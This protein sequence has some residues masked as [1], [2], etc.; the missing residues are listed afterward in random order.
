MEPA[1]ASAPTV[2]KPS[3]KP[4]GAR[5]PNPKE[6]SPGMASLFRGGPVEIIEEKPS[7]AAEQLPASTEKKPERLL[8][9]SWLRL[10]LVGTDLLL[11]ALAARLVFRAHG[12]IGWFEILLCVVAVGM[13]A[14]LSCLA[15]WRDS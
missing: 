15:L 10:S 5:A 13:G 4:P 14:W 12:R 8:N 11:L 3:E 7:E 1:K 9:Q 2:Q 6:L